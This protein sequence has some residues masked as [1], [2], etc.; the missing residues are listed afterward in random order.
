MHLNGTINTV[1]NSA[2]TFSSG[3][4]GGAAVA[5]RRDGAYGTYIDFWTNANTTATQYAS[6]LRMTVAADGNVSVGDQGTVDNSLRYLDIYNLA[7]GGASSVTGSN[8]R[9]IT[10]NNANTTT[11]IVDLVKYRNGSFNIANNDAG[12]SSVTTNFIL[13]LTDIM[14]LSLTSVAIPLSTPSTTTTSGALTV[15]GG[16]GVAGAL[17]LGSFSGGN[18]CVKPSTN[19]TRVTDSVAEATQPNPAVGGLVSLRTTIALNAATPP[20]VGRTSQTWLVIIKTSSGAS[21]TGIYLVT[22][23]MTVRN[24]CVNAPVDFTNS[25][26]VDIVGWRIA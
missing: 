5:F 13:N 10:K 8:V 18:V 19:A 22:G 25:D 26:N 20:V 24:A 21:Q 14:N 11:S 7:T 17:N 2:L 4:G 23:N 6:A 1:T 3:G 15:S 12:N 16:V 9:L